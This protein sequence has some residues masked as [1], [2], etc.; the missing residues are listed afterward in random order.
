MVMQ[1]IPALL[2]V[3]SLGLLGVA[4]AASVRGDEFAQALRARP[5]LAH[6]A[7]LFVGCTACHGSDGGG[8]SNGSVPRIAGQHASVLVKQLVDFRNGQRWDLRMEQVASR[9]SLLDPQ[10]IAD[11]AGF[12]ATQAAA[13]PAAIGTGENLR[14]GASVFLA[15]C[16]D[17]HGA[18]GLGDATTRVPRLAGQHAPYLMRQMQEGAGGGRPNMV[19]SHRALLNRLDVQDYA[20]I[21]DYLARMSPA[22]LN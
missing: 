13:L 3:F 2:A 14:H 16:A 1:R 12:V 4:Q 7:Q 8:E 9:H 6:G 11:V 5:D 22:P 19:A 21:A 20:G 15:L 10:A 18:V 17:C